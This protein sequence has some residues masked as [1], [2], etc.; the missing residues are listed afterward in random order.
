M[1]EL[2]LCGKISLLF[3][4]CSIPFPRVRVFR[5]PT[6]KG[7]PYSIAHVGSN[8]STQPNI[9]GHQLRS[10]DRTLGHTTQL[11]RY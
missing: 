8:S 10:L 4:F 2:G 11:P 9:S 5:V 1:Q 3:L 7:F 6:D